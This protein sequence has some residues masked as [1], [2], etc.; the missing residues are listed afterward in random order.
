MKTNQQRRD[1]CLARAR[2]II[3]ESAAWYN[4]PVV[5]LTG[6]YG[7]EEQKVAHS[8]GHTLYGLWNCPYCQDGLG[9]LADLPE[10]AGGPS[11]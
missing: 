6:K 4:I 8:L 9:S 11:N 7:W 3:A 2:E 10:S 1:E 5:D